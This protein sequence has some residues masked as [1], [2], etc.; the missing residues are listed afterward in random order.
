MNTASYVH[1]AAAP[2]LMYALLRC[3]CGLLPLL[4]AGVC[5]AEL[6]VLPAVA[7]AACAG[8]CFASRQQH[9]RVHGSS[10]PADIYALLRCLCGLLSLLLHMQAPASPH[11]NSTI[12]YIG[13]LHWWT[14]DAVLEAAVTEFGP[15]T[16]CR[17]VEERATGGCRRNLNTHTF[18]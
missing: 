8:A 10:S 9:H 2:L 7:P 16:S 15:V 14:T 1:M 6:P 12:V 4:H 11:V 3:L 13:N 18:V 17:F 5:L